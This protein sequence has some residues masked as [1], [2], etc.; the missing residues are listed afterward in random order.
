MFSCSPSET[1]ICFLFQQHAGR[2][3]LLLEAMLVVGLVMR[4]LGIRRCGRVR[5]VWSSKKH[6]RP[7]ED[8]SA[9]G[10]GAFLATP[11]P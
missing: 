7:F 4:L 1:P 11:P 8:F 2:M 3:L 6:K 5:G 10:R 9:S